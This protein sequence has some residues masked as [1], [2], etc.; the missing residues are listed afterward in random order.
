M[1]TKVDFTKTSKRSNNVRDIR[2]KCDNY[3]II[4]IGDDKKL[5]SF[6]LPFTRQKFADLIGLSRKSA[7][8]VLA[9]VKKRFK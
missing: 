8:R 9:N 5:I 7:T 3:H 4:F 2:S 1:R 6:E